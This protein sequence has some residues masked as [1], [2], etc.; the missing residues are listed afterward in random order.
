MRE[1]ESRDPEQVNDRERQCATTLES[2]DSRQAC[3]IHGRQTRE[4]SLRRCVLP[5]A[6][7]STAL[8]NSKAATGRRLNRLR[9]AGERQAP[10]SGATWPACTHVQAQRHGS[11]GVALAVARGKGSSRCGRAGLAAFQ[12]TAGTVSPRKASRQRRF[13]LTEQLLLPLVFCRRP[14]HHHSMEHDCCLRTF[15]SSRDLVYCHAHT[16][17]TTNG[18]N[19]A[20][21]P[22]L[23]NRR[24]R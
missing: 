8:G 4:R 9:F 17:D 12:V 7:C 5:C 10:A 19:Q 6:A 24:Q 22:F 14:D 20:I 2:L 1:E 15:E 3:L 16:P 18:R 21:N 13:P 23:G 11:R